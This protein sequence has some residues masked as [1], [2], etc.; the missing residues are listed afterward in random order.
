MKYCQRLVAP[1]RRERVG[2]RKIDG[3][4]WMKMNILPFLSDVCQWSFFVSESF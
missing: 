3:D 4:G 1:Q 2:D